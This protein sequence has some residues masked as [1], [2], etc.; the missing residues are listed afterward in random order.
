MRYVLL[1]TVILSVLGCRSMSSVRDNEEDGT[2][3]VYKGDLADLRKKVIGMLKGWDAEQLD[4]DEA[5]RVYCYLP[6][7]LVGKGTFVGVWFKQE[8]ESVSIRCLT[9]RW[10]PWHEITRLT[11]GGFHRELKET[12]G[13][14][15]PERP[16]IG[17]QAG[18]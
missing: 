9:K 12:L 2:T 11:E 5:D 15:V 3:D 4:Q 8:A 18:P 16:K 7:K 6:S 10:V 14:P 1:G 13:L 17:K